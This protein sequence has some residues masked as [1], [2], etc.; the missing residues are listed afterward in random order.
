MKKMM[1]CRLE[2]ARKGVNTV[3]VVVV[4]DDDDNEVKYARSG[5][6]PPDSVEAGV[7]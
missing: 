6:R 4:V 5:R 1:T 3:V 2:E 7:Q